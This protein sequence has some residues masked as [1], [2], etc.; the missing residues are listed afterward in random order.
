M[1]MATLAAGMSREAAIK[2]TASA[3]SCSRHSMA[4]LPGPPTAQPDRQLAL[5]PRAALATAAHSA[6]FRPVISCY[7][8]PQPPRS[9]ALLFLPWDPPQHAMHPTVTSKARVHR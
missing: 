4:A 7:S 1:G 5:A 8:A 6:A 9:I 3:A 2:V